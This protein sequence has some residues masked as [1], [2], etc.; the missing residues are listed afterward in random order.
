MFKYFTEIADDGTKTSVAINTSK[1]ACALPG[2]NE[3]ET[4]LR[5]ENGGWFVV[6]G[7]QLDNVARLNAG[8]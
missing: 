2:Q 7:S 1:I 5:F 8:E 6:E 3:N 4:I